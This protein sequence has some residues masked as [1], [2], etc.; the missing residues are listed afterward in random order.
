MGARATPPR[1]GGPVASASVGVVFVDLDRT[2]LRRASG[3]VLDRPWGRGGDHGASAPFPGD[4]L[5][6]ALYDRFGENPVAMGLARAAARVARG[7]RPGR[8]AGR[9]GAGP[10]R[11]WPTWWRRS[12]PGTWPTYRRAGHRL[13]LATTTPVDMIAPFAEALGFDD[14]VATRYEVRDGRYTGRLDGGFVWGLGKLAGGASGGPAPRGSTLPS[15][16]PARQLLRPA[17]ALERGLAPRGQPRPASDVVAAGSG[18]G[19]SST[20]TA[21]PAS[22]RW[23]GS[24]PTT[25]CGRS[26]DPRRSPTRASTCRASRRS[27]RRG[28]VLLASN[29]RSYFDVVALAIVAAEIGRPVRFLAKRELFDAPVDRLGGQVDRG[30]PGRPG[31]RLRTNRC[32]RPRR[33]CGPARW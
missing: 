16:T 28:P 25:C 3:P 18:A 5:L 1:H 13:V 24:S 17:P 23:S 4:R 32:A 2:L 15:A 30:H 31:Q 26:S 8:G 6:Y 27:R 11:S 7:W 33:P 19:R 12:P 9:R 10:C 22:R 14:V 20:G 21:R 29:H